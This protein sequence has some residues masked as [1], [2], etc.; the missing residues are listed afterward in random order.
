MFNAPNLNKHFP[1]PLLFGAI[2]IASEDL[3]TTRPSKQELRSKRTWLRI[4][5]FEHRVERDDVRRAVSVPA[6]VWPPGLHLVEESPGPLLQPCR[7]TGVDQDVVSLRARG[8]AGLDHLVKHGEGPV[9][10]GRKRTAGK[11]T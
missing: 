1:S 2:F 9:D 8:T 11:H 10:L 5:H 3:I 4:A 7:G 6:F